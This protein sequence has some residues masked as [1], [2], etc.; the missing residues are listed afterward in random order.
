MKCRICGREFEI[1][2]G[3]GH[4]KVG[5]ASLRLAAEGL[6]ISDPALDE[7]LTLCGVCL[8][9]GLDWAAGQSARTAGHA[10]RPDDPSAT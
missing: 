7:P 5:G 4:G 9:K 10:E 8:A 1:S 6:E 3:L 2:G